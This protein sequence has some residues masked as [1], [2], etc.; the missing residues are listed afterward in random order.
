LWNA[1]LLPFIYFLLH[2][3]AAYG[4][5]WL[6]RP[7]LVMGDD[8]L[9]VPHRLG[10]LL[11]APLIAVVLGV[12]VLMLSNTAAGWIK[13]NYEGYESKPAWPQYKQINDFMASQPPGR[14]MVEH[15]DKIDKFG[16][17]RA[18][19]ILPYW[20]EQ[21]TMEGT[22]ME[23]SFTAPYHFINQAELSVQPSNAIVGVSYPG[24]DTP[25]G[26]SHL[27]LM[28]IPY[29]I[30]ATPEVTNEV[31]ADPRADLLATIDEFNIFRIS[32]TTG[33]VEVMEN[34]PVRMAAEDWRTPVVEWYKTQT[35]L[36]TPIIWDRGEAELEEF[37]PITP[38][39][40]TNPPAVPI[41]GQGQVESEVLTDD[42][43]VFQTS[44]IGQ[45]HWIKISYFP[46]WKV[47]GADGPFVASPSF[48]MVI[49]R[50]REVT[51]YYGRTSSNNIGQLLSGIGWLVVL[52]V[53]ALQ[54]RR[55]VRR[56][57]ARP[58]S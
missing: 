12:V 2:L 10:R 35:A 20:T 34:R 49:P 26:L 56:R 21:P 4:A 37:A 23:A 46:N 36:N 28:N 54:V 33:Y 16:T 53:V 15:N 3:W 25:R 58:A 47:E 45:P 40:A 18:F 27:Q 24:R 52:G 7:F 13:W 57:R 42:R 1:R 22:L 8:L 30:T 51:L 43:L 50:E 32:G 29:L 9:D 48:M 38:A 31:L 44:A 17:P 5:A 39:E 11:Y 41:E 55:E 6:I 14:V 19:E